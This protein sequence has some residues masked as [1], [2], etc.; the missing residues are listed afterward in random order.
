MNRTIW[1][2]FLLLFLFSAVRAD[3][4]ADRLLKQSGIRGGF[5]VHLG[6]G[7]GKTT[8]GLRASE[9]YL[10]HGLDADAGNVEKAR[11]YI[12]GKGFYGPVFVEQHSGASLPY[13]DRIANLVVA[14]NPGEVPEE[15]ILRVLVPNGV[16]LFKN[17][18]GSWRKVIKPRPDTIDDWSHYLHDAGGN[19][20]ADDDEVAPPRNLQWVGSPRWSRHH[21]RMAS[22]S[23]L[24]TEGG[25]LFYIMDEGSRI[26]ILMPSRWKLIA[27]DAFNGVI[28]WKRDIPKWQN[29]LWP[30]K[31]G[32]TQLARRL[33][34]LDGKVFATLG[35]KAPVSIMDA[36]TG[37]T[38]RTLAGSE[39]T[40]ELI[41]KD[42]T[43]Y[44][45]AMKE[46]A[47]L[48][49]FLP[50]LNTGDQGRVAARYK[51]NEIP[52]VVMAYDVASGKLKWKKLSKIAPLT[53]AADNERLFFYDGEKVV[54]LSEDSGE[55]I[56]AGT[57]ADRRDQVTFNF[58]PKLVVYEDLVLFAGG[59]R[60][61][62]TYEAA[63][64]KELWNAAHAKGGYQSP[65]DLLVIGERVWSAPLTSGK[66]SGVFIGRNVRTGKVKT[67]FAPNVD[68]YWFHHRCYIAK[69]TKNFIMPSRTG[70]EFVDFEKKSWEI[71]HW[72][73]GGC[74]YGVM[75]ANGLTYTP[76]HDCACYPETKIYGFNALS[77]T[78]LRPSKAIPK[79]RLTKG[80]AFGKVEATAEKNTD[81]PTFRGNQARSGFT[82]G[83]V[84]SDLKTSWECKLGGRL[85]SVVVS[86]G[87]LFVSQ[88]DEHTVHALD[89]ETGEKIW[90]FTA[91][92]RVDSPPTVFKGAVFFGSAD[93]RVY[94]VRASDGVLIW[95][96]RAVP[97]D[98]RLMAFEQLE[99]VWPIHGNV[100]IQD[101]VIYFVAGRSNFLDGGLR[102]IRMEP[103]TGKVIG[104][105]VIDEIDPETGK[106]IQ[107]R[108]QVLQMPVGLP[109]ILTCDNGYVYMRS[110]Q[111]DLDGNRLDLG[112]HS[113]D[114]KIQGS[115][116]KGGEH[117]FAPMSFLD[118]SWFHR[119]YWVFGKSFAGGHNGYY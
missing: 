100:L 67:E 70:I 94:A 13:I 62:H 25:R 68:P 51:W 84:S 103:D 8:A 82:K 110:Q 112:P 21:D 57:P 47:E 17:D 81:W 61:V 75:P 31:S 88:I 64:G 79:D 72:V 74:L 24:V 4:T 58:G 92:G 29:H 2:F 107:D 77:S 71:N 19:A 118:D 6:S 69:A 49:D 65:E 60:K 59:D 11:E 113:G 28:L 66:D 95:K 99:S 111:F 108:H 87:K 46:K 102:M 115:T 18:D 101:G 15:E 42:G 89:A 119:S 10:V 35:I 41:V 30:L 5:V 32:P 86:G 7:D 98:R 53:L 91:A 20:V 36:A 33:V 85:S 9:A 104:E 90:S 80:P 40:E 50:Q 1:S 37:K 78:G 44:L 73:R 93:G 109:D 23:A 3:E 97:E 63:T 22:M 83:H 16:A 39:G 48:D 106:N 52:R 76:P 34:A 55:E 26:S 114:A 105:T 117:L 12:K 38:I 54:C 43:V 56:W 14:E 27:R 116:Q 45:M 96:F